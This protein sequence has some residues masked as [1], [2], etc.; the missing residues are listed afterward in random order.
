[1]K[2]LFVFVFVFFLQGVAYSAT[3]LNYAHLFKGYH[4]CFLLYNVTKQKLV[5]EYNPNHR[6]E[7]RISPDSTFKIPLSLMAFNQGVMNQDTVFP[8]S[9]QAGLLP[10]WNQDQSPRTWLKYSVVWVSQALTPK[11]GM[12]KI[13]RYLAAFAYGNQDFSGDPGLNNGL[14]YAWLSSSLKISAVEQLAFLM[15]MVNHDL[16]I[17]DEAITD[18]K[19]NLYLGKLANGAD[20]Y[21]KTGSGRHGANE[22][23]AHPSVLRDGWFV[24]LVEDQHQQYVFVSNLTDNKPPASSD[25]AYGSYLLKPITL[26]ILNHFFN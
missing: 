2:K 10:E 23:Q 5:S 18:T 11:L 17:R 9:G 1:M 6:C 16:P 15:A 4:A 25:H 8:W 21:G 19:Q 20:Y 14:T 3:Q 24:G 26:Q 22:R 13:K 7:E 12:E